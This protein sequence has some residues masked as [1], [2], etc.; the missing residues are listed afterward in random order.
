ML[1]DEDRIHVLT[2]YAT[3]KKKPRVEVFDFKNLEF[4]KM[5]FEE[6]NNVE[7]FEGVLRRYE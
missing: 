6:T 3:K 5:F 7:Q 1:V 4:Q 2:K